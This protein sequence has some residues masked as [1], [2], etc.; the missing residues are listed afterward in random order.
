VAASGGG[1]IKVAHGQ[2]KIEG[3]TNRQR[4][5]RTGLPRAPRAGIDIPMVITLA[6]PRPAPRRQRPRRPPETWR[7]KRV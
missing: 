6:I 1:S 3:R 5:E 7:D 2:F 4:P